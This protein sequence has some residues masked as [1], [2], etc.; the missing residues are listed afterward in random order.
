MNP[1]NC[2]RCGASDPV[3]GLEAPVLCE[4]CIL[5]ALAARFPIG[6]ASLEALAAA[7]RRSPADRHRPRRATGG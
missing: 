3:P 5:K 2:E 1:A 4:D 6:N 7:I